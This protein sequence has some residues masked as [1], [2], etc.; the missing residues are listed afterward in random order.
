MLHWN[1]ATPLLTATIATLTW[2]S[3]L[4]ALAVQAPALV[5]GAGGFVAGIG[6]TVFGTLWTTTMQREIPPEV[7]SR[8]S[9]YDWFGP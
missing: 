5:I 2:V 4:A 1:P 8:V 7:L 6:L 3:P 9:A